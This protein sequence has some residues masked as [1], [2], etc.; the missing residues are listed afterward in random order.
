MSLL[1]VLNIGT[2][3]MNVSQLQM[4]VTSQNISNADVEGYS[5][6][7]VNTTTAYHYDSVFGQMGMGADVID[8]ERMRNT[9]VDEQIRHQNMEVGYFE[10]MDNTLSRLEDVF[11]EPS[12]KGLQNYIDQFFDSWQNL[13]NNP[14]DVAART[15]VRSNAEELVSVFHTLSGELRDLRQERN[16]QLPS[17]VDRINQLSRQIFNLNQEVG[18]I[19]IGDQNANDSR[20]KRDMLVKELSKL[21]DIT[22]QENDNGQVT[23]TTAGSILVSP[24][25]TQDLEI[26]TAT[27]NLPDGTSVKDLGIRFADSNLAYDPKGGQVKGLLDSRDETIPAYQ[28]TL[29][30]LAVAITEKT[31]EIHTTGYTLNGYS[32]I[33]FFAPNATGASDINLSASILSDVLNIAAASGG[34]SHI[35]AQNTSPAGSHDYGTDPIQLYQD[36]S[37]AP[38]VKARNIIRDTVS[39]STGSVVL[40]E[41]TD[42]HIDYANGTFQMLHNGY[43]TQDLTIDFQYRS[44]GSKGPGDNSNALELAK[45]RTS[46]TM[47][48]DGL[49]NPTSTFSEFYSSFIG[50]LGLNKQQAS[51]NLETRTFLVDQYEAQQDS[52]SGVSLDEEMANMIRYQH[53]YT[54]AA[55]LITTTDEM[56]QVLMNI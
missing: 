16:D 3:G 26:T 52:V 40:T 27:R 32:G 45:L 24:V 18:A 5:R 19:E 20:D 28:K 51:S 8:I 35:A 43:D 47:S 30:E 9:F 33:S 44:G 15:M 46:L 34:Q 29:D 36:P 49:G 22:T 55:R 37:V 21:I 53:S 1:S 56:L 48:A 50:R 7:R 17:R 38:P 12:D 6:K 42:Y 10:E 39:V 2:K 13:A 54:A 25:F 4:D 11:T 41:G 23:I 14:S 31:N